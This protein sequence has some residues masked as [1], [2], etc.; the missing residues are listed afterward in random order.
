[1][2]RELFVPLRR[3]LPSRR[4]RVGV[5]DRDLIEHEIAKALAADAAS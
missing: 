1:V 4:D 2:S 5:T 3:L